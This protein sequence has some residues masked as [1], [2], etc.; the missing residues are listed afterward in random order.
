MFRKI[1]SFTT[2][3]SFIGM[4][5]TGVVLFI[6]PEGRVAYWGDLH[7]VGLTKDQWGD[8][9]TTLSALFMISGIL[10]TYLNWG[11][12]V[13]YFQSKAKKLIVFT[14]SFTISTIIFVI[15]VVGTYY[16]V[17]PFK[18]LLSL[19]DYVKEHWREKVGNPPY[20]HAELSKL[21]DLVKKEGLDIN[22]VVKILKDNNINFTSEE[23]KFIDIA[24]KNKK[25]PASLYDLIE[26]KYDEYEENL[27][28]KEDN[29]DN[30]GNKSVEKVEK[31]TKS[32]QAPSGLGKMK[33][34]EVCKKYGIET[35]DALAI[36]KKEGFN[37][38]EDMT[39][40]EIAEQ[41]GLVPID[42]FEII[43]KN[44]K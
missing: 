26:S 23:D 33:L 28:K 43:T 29:K 4:T 13:H 6:I 20:P 2:L 12:I 11:T 32:L 14:P 21:K 15:F 8:L 16:K 34:S 7:I 19:S 42:L 39:M 27:S 31:S 38:K 35:K 37:A 22:I 3:W 10:H 24:R 5:F 40:K 1:V 36:L 18:D 9:H 44:K 41:K 30:E 17:S 25:S